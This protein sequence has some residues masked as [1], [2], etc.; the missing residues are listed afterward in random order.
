MTED[1]GSCIIGAM[2]GQHLNPP[3]LPAPPGGIYD[4]VIR[5][6]QLIFISGQLGR[7][8][9]GNPVSPEDI[10]GQYRQVWKNVVVAVSAA[11]GTEADIVKTTTFVVGPDNIPAVRAVRAELCSSG[12]PTSTMVVV[13]ALA[14]PRYLVEVDAIAVIAP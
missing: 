6:G 5:V 9:S 7:D 4:H 14:D 11:G 2:S 1:H 3:D 13:A 12:P 10:A 8:Q